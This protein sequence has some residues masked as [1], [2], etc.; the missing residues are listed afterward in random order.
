[1]IVLNRRTSHQLSRVQLQPFNFLPREGEVSSLFQKLQQMTQSGLITSSTFVFSLKLRTLLPVIHPP[2]NSLLTST[3]ESVQ[4]F[5]DLVFGFLYDLF[6]LLLC[7]FHMF[8]H[9]ACHHVQQRHVYIF[10]SNDTQY[11]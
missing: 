5:Q 10:L 11:V 3:E 7:H 8:K 2:L 6:H 4:A 1:M 9:P